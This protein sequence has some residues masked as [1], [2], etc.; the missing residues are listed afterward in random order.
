LWTENKGLSAAE[1][2]IATQK[3]ILLARFQVDLI[4]PGP[5]RPFSRAQKIEPVK[6]PVRKEP[7]DSKKTGG[8][9]VGNER[10]VNEK[11]ADNLWARIQCGKGRRMSSEEVMHPAAELEKGGKQDNAEIELMKSI[12]DIT[13]MLNCKTARV[14]APK[15]ETRNHQTNGFGLVG[16]TISFNSTATTKRSY[17]C[18][19]NT[20][21]ASKTMAKS[22]KPCTTTAPPLTE[23]R[24]A[25]NLYASVRVQSTTKKCSN[26]GS[27]KKESS[28][29]RMIRGLKLPIK[30]NSIPVVERLLLTGKP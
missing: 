25:R 30:R 27:V 12:E 16:A 21:S 24:S 23:R 3:R 6:E 22:L 28:E 18:V 20:Q 4:E 10:A 14:L 2:R 7:T 29:S 15:L 13:K 9:R 1:I 8:E 11:V 5:Q 19:P 26:V 17:K